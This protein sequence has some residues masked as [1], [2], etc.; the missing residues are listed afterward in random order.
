[1][2][3]SVVGNGA[4]I[5][6][7]NNYLLAQVIEQ[8]LEQAGFSDPG[9]L[10]NNENLIH[11]YMNSS[12][13]KSSNWQEF[14]LGFP[15]KILLEDWPQ[16]LDNL[17]KSDRRQK[18]LNRLYAKIYGEHQVICLTPKQR[19]TLTWE[20]ISKTEDLNYLYDETFNKNGD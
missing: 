1:M 10:E 16:F 18:D 9:I 8:D 7:T 4:K 12:L 13:S 15:F 3:Y 20:I 19:E 6:F 11:L 2:I 17:H 14:A 5:H